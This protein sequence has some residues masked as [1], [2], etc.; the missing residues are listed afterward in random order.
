MDNRG[1]GC[2]L[3]GHTHMYPHTPSGDSNL[4]AIFRPDDWQLDVYSFPTDWLISLATLI[5]P[6]H[7]SIASLPLTT[8]FFVV[9]VTLLTP[10]CPDVPHSLL[11]YPTLH[12]SFRI[13][14]SLDLLWDYY[15]DR[16]DKGHLSHVRWAE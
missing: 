11:P 2:S 10:P 9:T 15:N 5:P 3:C 6:H 14:L 7:P 1:F 4:R 16:G 12:P 8:F 13:L